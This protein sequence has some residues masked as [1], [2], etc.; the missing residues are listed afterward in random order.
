M[1]QLQVQ[2]AQRRVE[3]AVSYEND[4]DY[5]QP[6]EV[7]PYSTGSFLQGKFLFYPSRPPLLYTHKENEEVNGENFQY[8][9][10]SFVTHSRF[11][12]Y[13]KYPDI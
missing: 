2:E 7:A 10:I 12:P 9:Y 5:T 8:G 11:R 6:G 4:T 3:R 13:E 1:D